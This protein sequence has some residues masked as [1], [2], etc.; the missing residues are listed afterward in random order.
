MPAPAT[1]AVVAI[2]VLLSPAVGVGAVGVPV[3]AG[4]ASGA[5]PAPVTSAAVSV[6]APVLLLNDPTPA[7]P[8][9]TAAL[10]NAVVATVVSLLAPAA[11]GAVGVP[12]KPGE[13][14]SALPDCSAVISDFA[15]AQ[16]AR[17]AEVSALPKGGTV[18]SMALGIRFY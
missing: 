18:A 3:S 2:L 11:V 7:V 15:V 1:N 17:S 10:T 16:F 12:V 14:R 8:P 13:L 9:T 4:E 6:T 5:P